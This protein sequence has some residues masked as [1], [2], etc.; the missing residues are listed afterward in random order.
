MV[1]ST[2]AASAIAASTVAAIAARSSRDDAEVGGFGAEAARRRRRWPTAFDE[3][4]W[5]GPGAAP[6]GT[7]SSPVETIGDP[8]PA[9]DGDGAVAHRGGERQLAHAEHAR[10]R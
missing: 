5:S 10:R 1:T 4:I 7:S 8:R 2:S 9:A 6:A 3:T